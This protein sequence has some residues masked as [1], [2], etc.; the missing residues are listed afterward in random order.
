MRFRREAEDRG[1]IDEAIDGV[2]GAPCVYRRLMRAEW[3][4]IK[5]RAVVDV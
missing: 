4:V 2:V 1:D 3:M 5:S